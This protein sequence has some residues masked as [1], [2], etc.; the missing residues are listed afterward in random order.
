MR[1]LA[2]EN[3]PLRGV[4]I[5]TAAGHDVAA[6]MLD[7][8]GIPDERVLSRAAHEARVLLTF[9]RD[10]GRLLYRTGAPV[11]EGVVYFRFDPTYPEETV[12][13]LL[14]LLEQSESSIPGKL[15]V[16][17]RDRVRQRPLPRADQP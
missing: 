15:T 12:E 17:E 6:I 7:S 4:E 14:A 1:F 2:D 10:H 16:V 11:P 9:D 5:L 3:F 13:Y 8:P